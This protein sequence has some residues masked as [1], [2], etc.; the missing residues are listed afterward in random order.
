MVQMCYFEGPGRMQMSGCCSSSDAGLH[1]RIVAVKPS[2]VNLRNV[3]FS[4][5]LAAA[6]ALGLLQSGAASSAC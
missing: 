1:V 5:P 2:S 3:S 4:A 6:E